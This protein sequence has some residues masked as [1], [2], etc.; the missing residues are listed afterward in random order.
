MTGSKSALDD[1]AEQL[2]RTTRLSESPVYGIRPAS[3]TF[4]GRLTDEGA[5]ALL[6]RALAVDISVAL[7]RKERG[8]CA[9]CG[10][11]RVRFQLQSN[12][13]AES[14]VVCGRCAG[15]RR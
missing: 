6:G 15:M 5:A 9:S 3:A 1:V 4:V 14:D 11:R 12:T 10:K 8:T 13:G 2:I 7:V